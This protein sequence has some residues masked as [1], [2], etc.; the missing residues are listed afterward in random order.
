MEIKI[1]NTKLP[2]HPFAQIATTDIE[3]VSGGVPVGDFK[4]V[5]MR[6]PED[7]IST[8]TDE[9]GVISK[10]SLESGDGPIFTTM[11]VG[12]EGGHDFPILF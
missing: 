6:H 10:P 5:T 8:L 2:A 12:E 11:A 9:G 3:Q 4:L 1:M 7:G